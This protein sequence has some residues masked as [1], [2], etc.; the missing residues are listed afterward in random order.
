M[1][2]HLSDH[3]VQALVREELEW[4]PDVDAA[5]VGVA[6]EDGVV[7][8]SGEVD[9]L[10][11]KLAAANAARR[12]RGVSTVVNDLVVHRPAASATSEAATAKAVSRALRSSGDI[13]ESVQAELQD[14]TVTLT[15][16]V[17]WDF[18]RRAAERAMQHIRGVRHVVNLLSLA[19]HAVPADTE[20]RI[21]AALD[22]DALLGGAAIEVSVDRGRVVL[23]GTVRSW[24][25]RSRAEHLAWRAP[26]VRSVDDF[27]DV[28]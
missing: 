27:I 28:R 4:T 1:S 2:R 14:G 9:A 17:G 15:G 18:E 10:W 3:D 19:P 20:E 16:R 22:R 5:G 13:P 23:T 25:E 24:A 21:R 6:V 7:T 11:E 12:V 26:Y 8:L